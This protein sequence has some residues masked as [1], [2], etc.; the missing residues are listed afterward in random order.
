MSL[1]EGV[2]FFMCLYFDTTS[3]EPRMN[4]HLVYLIP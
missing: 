2:Y 3:D 4:I 1:K